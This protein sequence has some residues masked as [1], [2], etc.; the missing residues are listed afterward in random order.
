VCGGDAGQYVIRLT[1]KGRGVEQTIY[2]QAG[3]AQLQIAEIL[4]AQRFTPWYSSLQLLSEQLA[5]PLSLPR[6]QLQGG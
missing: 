1:S 5:G 4:G 6:Q 2:D 3:A